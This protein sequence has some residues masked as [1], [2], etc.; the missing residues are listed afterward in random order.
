MWRHFEAQNEADV[1]F[2]AWSAYAP[3]QAG[4]FGL[5]DVDWV[6]C[7]REPPCERQPLLVSI[8]SRVR[9]DHV[10]KPTGI[11]NLDLDKHVDHLAA[12]PRVGSSIECRPRAGFVEPLSCGQPRIVTLPFHLPE[13]AT[14]TATASSRL[15]KSDQ[16]DQAC[17]RRFQ[18]RPAS[19][20]EIRRGPSALHRLHITA[21][22]CE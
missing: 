15:S 8:P 6:D 11:G 14:A 21:K 5:P 4:V 12:V 17:T 18:A 7:Q 19:S 16:R 1:H 10:D 3:L 2:V 13:V 22:C 9:D 20:R